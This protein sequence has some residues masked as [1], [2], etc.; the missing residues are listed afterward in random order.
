M[1][2]ITD[3][4]I[5][6]E[7]IEIKADIDSDYSVEQKIEEWGYS[8]PVVK[9]NGI[10]LNMGD[11]ES[12]NVNVSMFN[13]P[14]F[15]M[16]IKDYNFKIQ[17]K[18]TNKE[19]KCVIFIGNKDFY[20]KFNGIITNIGTSY[21]KILNI[22][23]IWYQKELFDLKQEGFVDTSVIDMLTKICT[24]TKLGLFSYDN[25]ELQITP[26][27][28]LNPNTKQLSFISDIIS[29]Y[30]SN[31]WSIDT[32]GFLHVGN[33]NSILNKPVDKYS[34]NPKNNSIIKDG[35]QDILLTYGR[36]RVTKD[37]E[38]KDD[39]KYKYAIEA[40]SLK[41][42]TDFSLTKLQSSQLAVLYTGT[43]SGRL[44][45]INTNIGIENST[46]TEN[47]FSGFLNNKY[48]L[49]DE[50]INK[51]LYGNVISLKLKNYMVEIVPFTL[52]NLEIY[53]HQSANI[54]TKEI[55]QNEDGSESI[56]YDSKDDLKKASYRLDEIHSGKHFVAGY[57]YHYR[58]NRKGEPNAI[59][60]DLILI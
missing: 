58:K 35:P 2:K 5:F 14:T 6:V 43:G 48:P 45:D 13:I 15:N 16:T 22:S 3:P 59:T 38:Q 55:K 39:E 47:T 42:E 9:I 56:D 44:L 25:N 8:I 10:T 21:T 1:G 34:I 46:E 12:L 36:N 41:I 29:T 19:D 50:R 49:R 53:Y 27:Y 23:G 40:E 52:V 54:I 57:S 20:V 32:F 18:L 11:I 17:E 4:Q 30:T 26:E 24:D 60:Q 33:L 37:N 28:H 51:L 7:D 31:L